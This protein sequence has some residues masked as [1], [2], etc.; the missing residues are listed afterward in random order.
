MRENPTTAANRLT[1]AELE[2]LIIARAVCRNA[3]ANGT[4]ALPQRVLEAAESL[5][6]LVRAN[7]PFPPEPAT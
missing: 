2:A 3:V 5:D 6:R 4:T 7:T 1:E